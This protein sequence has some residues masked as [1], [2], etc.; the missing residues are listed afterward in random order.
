VSRATEFIAAIE[1][2]IFQR[3]DAPTAD[4]VAQAN[5][6]TDADRREIGEV[7]ARRLA[8]NDV[9]A[10]EHVLFT[11]AHEDTLPQIGEAARR[12]METDKDDE[13]VMR[14]LAFQAPAVLD[15]H[16]E[17]LAQHEISVMAERDMQVTPAVG[18]ALHIVPPPGY[19]DL[20]AGV[21]TPT[22]LVSYGRPVGSARCGGSLEGRCGT[23]GHPLHLMLELS[24]MPREVGVSVE[25]LTVATCLSCLGWNNE[26]LWFRH[27]SDGS[28]RALTDRGDQ[29]ESDFPSGPFMPTSVELVDFGP[30]YARQSWGTSNGFENLHRLGG[31]PSWVQEERVLECCECGASMRHLLQLDSGFLR[32][33]DEP[34]F[35]FGSGGIA[36]VQWCDPCRLSAQ[37]WQCT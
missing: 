18:P 14:L 37:F 29:Y 28:V 8:A 32:T 11:F 10:I 26:E 33:N 9:F 35:S 34:R 2:T 25:R 12:R 7:F 13:A 19:G 31:A 15:P 24:K 23:C 20:R 27:G 4:L 6:L 21:P 30:R 16:R 17:W 5:A 1:G 22:W 3:E 36:Y